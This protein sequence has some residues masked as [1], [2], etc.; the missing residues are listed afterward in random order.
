MCVLVPKQRYEK[1][2]MNMHFQ[3]IKRVV[4]A[5]LL[6]GSSLAGC[7]PK[8]IVDVYTPSTSTDM[9]VADARE[10]LASL[11]NRKRINIRRE[12]EDAGLPENVAPMVDSST[13]YPD[14]LEI[15]LAANHGK[16]T[17]RFSDLAGKDISV[18]LEGGL[19]KIEFPGI[20]FSTGSINGP[21]KIKQ[22]A[23][24]LLRIQQEE[25]RECEDQNARVAAFEKT[26]EH[27][28]SLA[29]KPQISEDERRY[30]VQ[31]NLLSKQKEYSKAIEMFQKALEIDPTA[32]P[33][34]YFNMA[35]LAAQDSR[36]CMAIANMKMYL[37]LEPDAEDA[38]SAQDKI[39]EW[40][41]LMKQ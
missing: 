13:A 16:Y 17:L 14:R 39:Y 31:A 25:Q 26:A 23:D 5:V 36:Y 8:G 11:L 18:K 3:P 41:L 15:S 27:Y 6:L 19:Y 12:V 30:L 21:S 40:E 22:F 35:L 37:L 4:L 2:L 38:R 20:R 32:Y 1:G 34:A 9:T 10:T 28:R 33:A 7:A 24:A 29:V